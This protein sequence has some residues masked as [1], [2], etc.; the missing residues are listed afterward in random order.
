MFY[1]ECYEVPQD[2][3]PEDEYGMHYWK[4]AGTYT[5]DEAGYSDEAIDDALNGDPDAY[6]NID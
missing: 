1:Y 3:Y 4:Y 2:D 6:W 5:Q